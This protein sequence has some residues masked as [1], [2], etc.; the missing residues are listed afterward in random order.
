MTRPTIDA[1]TF[2]DP[3]LR[4]ALDLV[5]QFFP[6]HEGE[7]TRAEIDASRQRDAA[8]QKPFLSEPSVQQRSVPGEKGNPAVTVFAIN[9]EP[10]IA[11]PAILHTHG[12]GFVSGTAAGSV[13][14]MQVVA[15]ALDCVVVTVEYRLAPET[16]IQGSL[17]DN[18][19]ALL[20]LYRN[21]ASLGVDPAR[22]A[23]MGESAGG[24]HAAMLAL[25][26]RNRGEVPICFQAL[27]SP[28]LDD[29]TGSSVAPPAHVGAYVW[30]TNFNVAGWTA[31]LGRPAGSADVPSGFV[32]A[33][34]ED[35]SG[36]PAT[37]I[38]TGSADLF[39]VED[40]DYARRL[41]EAGVSTELHVVPGGYHAF[42]VIVSASSASRRYRLALLNALARA[43][44]HPE[45][46][47]PP[48][49]TALNFTPPAGTTLP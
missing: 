24:G 5:L 41:I 25:A 9:S 49:A 38:G 10:G 6:P 18:Y 17:E 32:P 48:G 33:R 8:M 22:I 46:I 30:Q 12:G 3:E 1:L 20:W 45:M 19:T 34:V 16:T 7:V 40:I 21:A 35:L 39:V 14:D 28:M 27:T 44:G 4:P 47:V 23:V 31:L 37:F 36:L 26:A 13:A 15:K 42:D 2:I 43:F 29:R 11:R